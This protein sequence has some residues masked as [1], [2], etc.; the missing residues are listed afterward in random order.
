[1]AD[2]V[3]KR[4][5]FANIVWWQFLQRMVS[6]SLKF[7]FKVIMLSQSYVRKN[8]KGTQITQC[9]SHTVHVTTP[10]DAHD[11]SRH[12]RNT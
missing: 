5:A 9:N 8:A 10:H 7:T 12:E 3:R 11:C 4:N 6:S 2:G 1:M